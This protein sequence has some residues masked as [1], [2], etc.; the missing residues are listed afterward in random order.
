MIITDNQCSYLK[1][2]QRS[3]V[4]TILLDQ[5]KSILRHIKRLLLTKE[6]TL[7]FGLSP[8]SVI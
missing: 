8:N 2:L 1:N 5:E 7:F 4:R 3:I 6:E